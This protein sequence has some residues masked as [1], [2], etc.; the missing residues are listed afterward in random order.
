MQFTLARLPWAAQAGAGLGASAACAVCFHLF[1]ATP[2]RADLAAGERALAGA[3]RDLAVAVNAARRLP[4]GR[5]VVAALGLRLEAIRG[6]APRE[7]DA[8]AVLRDVQVLAE[9]SGLWITGFKPAPPVIRD[10]MTEWSVALEFDGTYASVVTFLQGVADDP[11][12]ITVSTLRLRAHEH[13]EVES[14]VTGACR[15]TT[16]VPR[17]AV[18][19]R[20]ARPG[21]TAHVRRTSARESAAVAGLP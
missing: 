16:F 15:L 6:A 20:G 8:A 13:P 11:R 17:D 12:L 14:T 4:E 1:W 21:S 7:A 3:R 9:E 5:R 2:A 10:S 19:A 18:A